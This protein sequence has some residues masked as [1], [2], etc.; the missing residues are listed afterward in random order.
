MLQHSPFLQLPW[1]QRLRRTPL[2][3][4]KLRMVLVMLHFHGLAVQRLQ[5]AQ[6]V[7]LLW[8]RRRRRL[9]RGRHDALDL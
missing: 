4:R 2:W 6:L 1:M 7:Q 9:L 8:M 5:H 3:R